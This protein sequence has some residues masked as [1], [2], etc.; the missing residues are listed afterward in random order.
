MTAAELREIVAPHERGCESQAAFVAH[1]TMAFAACAL[2]AKDTQRALAVLSAHS[3]PFAMPPATEHLKRVTRLGNR[4][5]GGDD[6]V[7]R[8]APAESVAMLLAPMPPR[9]TGASGSDD[10]AALDALAQAA[11][12][13]L[14]LPQVPRVFAVLVPAAPTT[15]REWEWASAMWPLAVPRIRER[16]TD[17]SALPA[18]TVA[19]VAAGMAAARAAARRSAAAGHLAIGAA[20]V[21][22]RRCAVL[23]RCGCGIDAG[24]YA[25]YDTSADAGESPAVSSGAGQETDDGPCAPRGAHAVF[26]VLRRVSQMQARGGDYLCTDLALVTTHEPCVMCTMALVHSRIALAAFARANTAH[27]GLGGVHHVHRL[28]SL[29]HRFPA[30]EVVAAQQAAPAAAA[31][32]SDAA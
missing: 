32:T 26:E 13:A 5:G 23:A 25:P 10:T 4:G 24:T 27:G 22:T 7:P 11:A 28:P 30:Y 15:P 16:A 17:A 12:Q 8:P 19:A 21:D 20:V 1:R 6:A 3:S 31:G 2:P 9:D 14:G 18:A 29:N